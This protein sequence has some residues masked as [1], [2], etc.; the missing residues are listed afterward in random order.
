MLP[1]SASPSTGKG[2]PSSDFIAYSKGAF[3]ELN[4]LTG[5]NAGAM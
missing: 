4:A 3:E 5:M 1:F 2:P